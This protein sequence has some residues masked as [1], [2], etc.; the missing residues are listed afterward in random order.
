MWFNTFI[1]ADIITPADCIYKITTQGLWGESMFQFP[2]G[3]KLISAVCDTQYPF[4][5]HSRNQSML[6]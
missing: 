3:S 1:P 6:T 4:P 5:L 2:K